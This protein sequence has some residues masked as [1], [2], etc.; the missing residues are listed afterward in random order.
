[1]RNAAVDM[2]AA[3]DGVAVVVDMPSAVVAEVLVAVASLDTASLDAVLLDA[4]LRVVV[5]GF[6]V[7]EGSG[8]ADMDMVASDSD[9]G[10]VLASAIGRGI[11]T[12]PIGTVIQPTMDIP[13]IRIRMDTRTPRPMDTIMTIRV[14][15]STVRTR[16]RVIRQIRQINPQRTVGTGSGIISGRNLAPEQSEYVIFELLA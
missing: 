2:V 13:L 15:R 16:R 10:W 7:A 14:R 3:E 8:T 11:T 4:A 12:I 6:M 9:S 5:A 1:L